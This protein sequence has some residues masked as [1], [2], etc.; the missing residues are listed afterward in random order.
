MG[1]LKVGK[2][3]SILALVA[4]IFLGYFISSK[5][6]GGDNNLMVTGLGVKSIGSYSEK[7]QNCRLSDFKDYVAKERCLVELYAMAYKESGVNELNSALELVVGGD[8]RGYVFCH[9]ALHKAGGLLY[10]KVDDGKQFINDGFIEGGICDNGL[11]HGYYDALGVDEGFSLERWVEAGL[12][13]KGFNDS[14]ITLKGVCGDGAGHAV[15]QGSRDLEVSFESCFK[16]LDSVVIRACVTGVLMQIPKDDADGKAAYFGYDEMDD[17]WG[18][19]C[20]ILDKVLANKDLSGIESDF[21]G[22][23]SNVCAI[24]GGQNFSVGAGIEL[25]GT[26][27]IS[28]EAMG[29]SYL[30]ARSFCENLALNSGQREYELACLREYATQVRF[31]VRFDSDL[32]DR[33]CAMFT[34]DLREVCLKKEGY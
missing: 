2:F 28:D 19:V 12:W 20:V 26:P 23:S 11:I 4:L 1:F 30:K 16:L 25:S 13:C 14:E 9:S 3:V 24:M 21:A 33:Y 17:R 8:L 22:W 27:E 31:L 15:W 7:I 5:I 32:R 29:L 6:V 34:R 10:N 18:E